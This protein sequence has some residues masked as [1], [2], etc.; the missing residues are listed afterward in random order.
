MTTTVAEASAPTAWSRDEIW[1]TMARGFGQ[2]LITAGVVILLFVAYELWFTGYY[3]QQQQS[4]L[5]TQI[6]KQWTQNAAPDVS[7]VAPDKVKIGSGIA[8]LYIPRFGKHYHFVVVEGVGT[9]DLKKGPGHYPGT[10]LPGQIG[11][12]YV[13]GHRTTYLHPFNKIATLRRGDKIV[14]ETKSMWFTYTIQ[15][16]P[17]TNIRWKEIVSPTDVAAAVYPVPDQSN[18]NKKPTLRLL[19]F[20]SCH[21]EYSASERYIIHAEL[22][23]SLPKTP[24]QYPAALSAPVGH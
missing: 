8:V 11:N 6:E 24:G 17:G 3:T 12:F 10:A 16:I 7:T 22:T 20:S 5:N 15:D 19:T 4:T 9:D 18:P 23:Q 14:L 21:P 13:A 2:L 1:R